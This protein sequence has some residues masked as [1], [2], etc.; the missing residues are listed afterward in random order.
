MIL[1]EI[2][3]EF[4]LQII[5]RQRACR[6]AL[7]TVA[8]CPVVKEKT[9]NNSVFMNHTSTFALE[10]KSAMQRPCSLLGRLLG[11]PAPVPIQRTPLQTG[12]P[13]TPRKTAALALMAGLTLALNPLAARA[14]FVGPT[15]ITIDGS[16]ADWT[17]NVY[18]QTDGYTPSGA[19]GATDI[20]KFWYAMP[21]ATNNI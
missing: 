14:G 4:C 3:G 2:F 7:G 12:I 11:K 13:A 21:M 1:N 9:S 20:T 15:A 17:N 10:T 19:N 5:K 16:F 18:S 6:I 8:G